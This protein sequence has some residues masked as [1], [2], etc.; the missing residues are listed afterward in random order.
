MRHGGVAFYAY[1]HIH[2]QTYIHIHYYV[3]C[4]EIIYTI[5]T[6][7]IHILNP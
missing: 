2:M 7:Y 5:Y 1:T 6:L 4:I 3:Q